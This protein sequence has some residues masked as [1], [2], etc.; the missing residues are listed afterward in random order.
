MLK[1]N[2]ENTKRIASF[3]Q[4]GFW[5]VQ[6]LSKI[7]KEIKNG[8]KDL[9]YIRNIIT[10]TSRNLCEKNNLKLDIIPLL[11]STNLKPLN[12][13]HKNILK[14]PSIFSTEITP[15]YSSK[16]PMFSRIPFF[17]FPVKKVRPRTSTQKFYN[18]KKIEKEFNDK[19]ELIKL[20]QHGLQIL[21][22]S[23]ISGTINSYSNSKSKRN[24]E[25][26]IPNIKMKQLNNNEF[27]QKK[28]SNITNNNVNKFSFNKKM[29]NKKLKLTNDINSKINKK[30]L[31]LSQIQTAGNNDS[32]SKMRRKFKEF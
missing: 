15:K 30:I 27:R 9:V 22:N 31:Y 13:S 2:Y 3:S 16:N 5:K 24:I 4:R 19:Y 10:N 21:Q 14:P 29:I 26:I 17:F 25:E 20:Y 8:K 28:C 1:T 23:E 18:S 6:A 7:N 12:N 11:K 32:K